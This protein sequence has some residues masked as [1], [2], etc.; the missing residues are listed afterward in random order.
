MIP[1]L[2]VGET[3]LDKELRRTAEVIKKQLEVALKNINLNEYDSL[4]IA[5]EPR[6][7]IG[8]KN[9][10][11]KDDIIDVINYIKKIID[12]MGIKK[13]KLLYGGAISSENIKE[14]DCEYLDGYLLGNSCVSFEELKKII[15]CIKQCKEE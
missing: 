13:Y 10:L 9:T 1:I 2:C 3:K 5:Y 7:L 4:Y 15:E 14:I 12:F 8:G 6:Y 11:S